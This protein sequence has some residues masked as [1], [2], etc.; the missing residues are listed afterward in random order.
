MHL[1]IFHSVRFISVSKS[2]SNMNLF[3][4]PS[5]IHLWE[6]P[7]QLG[8][9]PSCSLFNYV[10]EV[11]RIS[12]VF[13]DPKCRVVLLTKIQ[14]EFLWDKMFWSIYSIY[15]IVKKK[16]YE[17]KSFQQTKKRWPQHAWF[18]VGHVKNWFTHQLFG[19]A[20]QERCIQRLHDVATTLLYQPLFA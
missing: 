10:Y 4:S 3:T 19:G 1:C 13:L 2:S 15:I 11:N 17:L 14:R 20:A 5:N 12:N 9:E 18:Q 7:Q 16:D 8:F 6:L